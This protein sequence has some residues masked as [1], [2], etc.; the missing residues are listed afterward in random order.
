MA[1]PEASVKLLPQIAARVGGKW[2]LTLMWDKSM[3]AV[4]AIDRLVT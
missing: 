4:Q 3:A 1:V 2:V